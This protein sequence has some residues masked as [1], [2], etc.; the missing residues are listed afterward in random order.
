MRNF[1]LSGSPAAPITLEVY[2]DYECPMCRTFYQETLPGI[3]AQYVA[4][5]KIQLLH[6][7]FPLSMHQFSKLAA[8]YA[9]A[10][11]QLGQAQYEFVAAQIFRQQQDW[12]Q[13]GNIDAVVVKVL[14]PGDMQKVRELVK[15]DSHLDDAVTAD[16]A[17]GTRDG[18]NVT[19]TLVVVKNGKRT[20]ID[21]FVPLPILKSYLDQLLAR[22]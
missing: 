4:T 10:A 11:G 16:V 13:N 14:A 15:N 3:Q 8:R 2:T 19:P 6:R 21:G 5:G 22:S 7:D 12:S 17:M 18:L 20:K 9:N 1:K